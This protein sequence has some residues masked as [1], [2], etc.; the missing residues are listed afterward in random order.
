METKETVESLDLVALANVIR[1]AFEPK[2]EAFKRSSFDCDSQFFRNTKHLPRIRINDND[3]FRLT[4]HV[5]DLQQ[6]VEVAC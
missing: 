5:I 2:C 1:T 4:Y 3:V 6:D